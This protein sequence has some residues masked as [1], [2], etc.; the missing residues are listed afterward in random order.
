MTVFNEDVASAA[1]DLETAA[2]R[3]LRRGAEHEL[4]PS[5]LARLDGYLDRH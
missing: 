2:A 4:S 3:V 5:C 1:F